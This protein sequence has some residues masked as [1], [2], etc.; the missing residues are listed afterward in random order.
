MKILPTPQAVAR[1]AVLVIAG[2]L[3]A[4]LILSQAPRLRAY[5]Q[6]KGASGCSCGGDG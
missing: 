2:A 6:S 3:L 5:I 4:A 1:E